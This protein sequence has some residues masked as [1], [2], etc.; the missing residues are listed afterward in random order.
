MHLHNMDINT[1]VAKQ[2]QRTDH[3]KPVQGQVA[4]VGRQ[5]KAGVDQHNHQAEVGICRG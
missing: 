3:Q 5:Q 2:Q 1:G 4:L